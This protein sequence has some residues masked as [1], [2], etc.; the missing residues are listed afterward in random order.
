MELQANWATSDSYELNEVLD[1]IDK[2]IIHTAGVVALRTA[3]G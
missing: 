3:R 2:K 1:V